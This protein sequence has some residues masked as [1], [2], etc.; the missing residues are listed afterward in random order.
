[1]SRDGRNGGDGTL[2]LRGAKVVDGFHS[3]KMCDGFG[4]GSL[5]TLRLKEDVSRFVNDCLS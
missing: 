5:K 4:L 2:V 3:L 1:M